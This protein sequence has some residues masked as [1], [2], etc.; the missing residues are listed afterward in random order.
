MGNPDQPQLHEYFARHL[1]DIAPERA[2]ST[3]FTILE[4]D[5]RSDLAKVGVPT[6]IVQSREDVAVPMAVARYLHEHI[7]HSQLAV[8][9]ATGHLPHLSAPQ[10]VVE[11]M[12]QFGV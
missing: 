10:A 12:R 2:A 7:R 8:I 9:E 6:L 3:L 1:G 11:A 4:S 5:H